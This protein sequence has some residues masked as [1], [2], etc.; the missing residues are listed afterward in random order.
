VPV[1]FVYYL[2]TKASKAAK[3]NKSETNAILG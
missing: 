1:S 2:E 3:V